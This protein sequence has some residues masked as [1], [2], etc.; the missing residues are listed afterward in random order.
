MG[1]PSI[2]DVLAITALV[3]RYAELLDGGDLDGVAALFEHASWGS[4][5]REERLRG[6]DAVRKGYRG[7][8]IYPEGTPRTKHVIT[9]L[10]IEIDG[11]DATTASARSY[12]TVMQAT[13]DLPLQP[14]IAGRYHDQFDKVDG[15]WR[16]SER[17][18]HPELFGDL[19]HHMRG[20][21]R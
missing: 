10:V 2:A 20:P 9:N 11:G 3:H 12:F 6:T 21:V 15:A 19:S 18:I 14:I 4:S 8:V 7:V 13:D 5:T 1:D 16:F 17:I